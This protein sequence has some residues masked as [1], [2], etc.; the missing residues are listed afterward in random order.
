MKPIIW[1]RH[2][3][4]SNIAEPRQPSGGEGPTAPPRFSLA[5]KA[6]FI[7][8]AAGLLALGG[9][10]LTAGLALLLALAAGGVLIGAATVVRHRLFGRPDGRLAPGEIP[11]AATVLPTSSA[12]LPATPPVAGPPTALAVPPVSRAPRAD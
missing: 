3:K 12:T 6:A 8:L 7:V 5:D 4:I 2:V 9:V 11:A 10:L 1:M